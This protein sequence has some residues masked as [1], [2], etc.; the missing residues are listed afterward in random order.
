MH[1]VANDL[2]LLIFGLCVGSFLNVCI[3]RF[4]RGESIVTPRSY[5][6]ACRKPIA[7]YD[8][9]P[10]FSFIILGGKCRKCTVPISPRYFFIEL[11]T[12]LA[13]VGSIHYFGWT[14]EGAAS[15]VFLTFLLGMSATDLEERII[16]DEMSLPGIMIGLLF[17]LSFPVLQQEASRWQGLLQSF[18]GM[19]AGGGMI[20][21]AGVFG[22]LLFRKE[23]MGGGDI[24]LMA[25]VGAFL[26]WKEAI[27][28]FFLAPILALPIGLYMK[29]QKKEDYIPY[30]P[31]LSL[32]GVIILF[33]GDF[34]I[35]FFFL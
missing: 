16:P 7:W 24:K 34:L 9:I 35:R 3:H 15:I 18:F 28:V 26:G 31:F 17:S 10:L 21:A 30:G 11:L 33:F 1:S 23:S 13:F 27:L 20:Y 29:F 22:E 14:A 4:L 8:N 5:C 19:V 12:G 32:A 25:M 6:P 2:I